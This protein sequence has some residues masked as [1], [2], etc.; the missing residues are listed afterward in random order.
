MQWATGPLSSP[1]LSDIV[2]GVLDFL[3]LCFLPAAGFPSRSLQAAFWQPSGSLPAALE[4]SLSLP[5]AL[6]LLAASRRPSRQ[7]SRH[8]LAGNI[9]REYEHWPL[10]HVDIFWI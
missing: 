2:P 5:A 6:Q 9:C 8:D 4:P 3:L 7:P 10:A 1:V